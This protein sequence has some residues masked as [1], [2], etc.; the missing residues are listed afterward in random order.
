[1]RLN[2]FYKNKVKEL[3]L[4]L[5]TFFV[6]VFTLN[7]FAQ[8]PVSLS[9]T[10]P[11]NFLQCIKAININDTALVLL[12]QGNGSNSS[13]SHTQI[14]CLDSNKS[15]MW[16]RSL[17]DTLF[18]IS[19]YDITYTNDSNLLI[20]GTLREANTLKYK[21]FLAKITTSGD[22]IYT[23][24]FDEFS[25]NLSLYKFINSEND[26]VI[27]YGSTQD[28][29][30][31][32]SGSMLSFNHKT[33]NIVS[34]NKFSD[35]I[36][37]H[38]SFRSGV[39][40]NQQEKYYILGTMSNDT[41]N[42]FY[43]TFV[44]QL[45]TVFNV[46]NSITISDLGLS[47][48]NHLSF[49]KINS[50][51]YVFFNESNSSPNYSPVI[52]KL[53]TN[54]NV[55]DSKI[56][57]NKYQITSTFLSDSSHYF[58]LYGLTEQFV[59][60]SNLNLINRDKIFSH[61]L[62]PNPKSIINSTTIFRNKLTRFGYLQY[63]PSLNYLSFLSEMNANGTGCTNI[64]GS[65]FSTNHTLTLGIINLI[66]QPFSFFSEYGQYSFLSD[67]LILNNECTTVG[68]ENPMRELD[69][70]IYPI[71]CVEVINIK[72]LNTN[73][74]KYS[75]YEIY[76]LFSRKVSEGIFEEKINVNHLIPG[77]YLLKL[78]SSDNKVKS[79]MIIKS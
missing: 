45:D 11:S 75:K 23:F 9:M 62:Y 32:G 15:L 6:Y 21:S 61:P 26:L 33:K 46:L 30:S 7:T 76:D 17:V 78:Y 37:N 31:V 52:T 71:P 4:M 55:L 68:I 48:S 18:S 70:L 27:L 56:L 22:T 51:L 53:D 60:D 47:I 54:L 34:S 38:V 42:P 64:Q 79:K 24:V 20:V 59:L 36:N 40:D 49:E 44:L 39:W 58:F 63:T 8:S 65:A 67:T 74:M 72:S 69:I 5:I 43:T 29:N 77:C 19:P 12:Q 41:M 25:L 13:I 2:L 35:P 66:N 14:T 28:T 16:C 3:E 1:M 73:Q 50:I 57:N 10:K